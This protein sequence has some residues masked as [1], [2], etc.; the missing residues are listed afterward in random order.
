MTACNVGV[1]SVLVCLCACT[2]AP[3]CQLCNRAWTK[4]QLTDEAELIQAAAT[5]PQVCVH[6]CAHVTHHAWYVYVCN[7]WGKAVRV[8][9]S[10]VCARR[11]SLCWECAG[12]ITI[13]STH[14]HHHPGLLRLVAGVLAAADASWSQD[15]PARPADHRNQG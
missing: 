10:D 13:T 1:A 11:V 3:V 14:L 7:I 12:P 8:G 5:P 2:R 15:R 4:T 6:A 9:V